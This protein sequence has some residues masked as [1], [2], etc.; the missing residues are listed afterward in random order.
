MSRFY[1]PQVHDRSP[2][3][4]P[5]AA[6]DGLTSYGIYSA[7]IAFAPVG[8]QVRVVCPA[9]DAQSTYTASCSTSSTLQPG[10]AVLVVFD[11]RKLP[12]V[13]KVA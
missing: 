13:V 9:L 1:E 10:D 8:G 3:A 7:T 4:A 12:W 6:G 11:E 2:G 5:Y